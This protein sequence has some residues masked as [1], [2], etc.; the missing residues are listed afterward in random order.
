M[1]PQSFPIVAIPVDFADGVNTNLHWL[2]PLRDSARLLQLQALMDIDNNDVDAALHTIQC[3]LA[4]GRSIQSNTLVEQLVRVA[5][6]AMNLS[7]IERLLNQCD[8]TDAQLE[9]MNSLIQSEDVKAGLYAAVQ[10]ECCMGLSLFRSPSQASFYGDSIPIRTMGPLRAIGYLQRDAITYL[11]FMQKSLDYLDDPTQTGM[12]AL[13]N[14]NHCGLFSKII[15]PALARVFQIA[16]RTVAHQRAAITACAIERYR[17]AHQ[18][19][20][21]TLQD[22]VPACLE[23]VPLDPFDGEPLRYQQLSLGYVVYSIGEDLSDDGG[24]EKERKRGAGNQPW[25]V[26]FIMERE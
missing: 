4:L 7:S 11:D 9:S 16:N 6:F 10:G 5:V 23:A 26:T 17:I 8:P 22:L 2:S 20:P 12:Q 21:A 24:Q 25:D 18:Q 13:E 19:L 14:V 1:R 3:S 15:I